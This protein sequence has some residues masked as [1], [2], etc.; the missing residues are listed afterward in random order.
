[1]K[2]VYLKETL[3]SLED[4]TSS[5]FIMRTYVP[6]KVPYNIAAWNF[7]SKVLKHF[8]NNN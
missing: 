4:D 5:S 3:Q 2:A 1:M 7:S 6:F 8:H